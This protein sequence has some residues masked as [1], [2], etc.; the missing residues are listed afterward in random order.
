M[1]TRI[2]PFLFAACVLTILSPFCHEEMHVNGDLTPIFV[3]ILS[4]RKFLFH[5]INWICWIFRNSDGVVCE[6]AK[7]QILPAQAKPA[8]LAQRFKFEKSFK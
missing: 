6:K 5:I 1:L 7:S 4:Y 8:T 2:V 3:M